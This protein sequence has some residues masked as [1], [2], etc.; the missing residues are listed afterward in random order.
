MWCEK[1]VGN[2][3]E[4]DADDDLMVE[5]VVLDVNGGPRRTGDGDCPCCRPVVPA[6]AVGAVGAVKGYAAAAAAAQKEV[7][8]RDVLVAVVA[9]A[10]AVAVAVVAVAATATDFL[11]EHVGSGRD[12]LPDAEASAGDRGDVS[13]DV[14]AE[15]EE[16]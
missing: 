9:V 5:S 8:W 6:D 4:N 12:G 3:L 2:T 11:E 16:P 7:A 10:V 15:P 13:G 14:E 1:V